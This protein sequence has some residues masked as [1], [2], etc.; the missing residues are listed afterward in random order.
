MQEQIFLSYSHLDAQWTTQLQ[1]ALQS[2]G[3]TVWQDR[4]RL[5][6]GESWNA[7]LMKGLG[8]AMCMVAVL[9]PRFG[10]SNFVQME[11]AEATTKNKPV[12]PVLQSRCELPE[13]LSYLSTLQYVDFANEPFETALN[14]LCF[15]LAAW[16]VSPAADPAA[17]IDLDLNRLLPGTWNINLRN[18]FGPIRIEALFRADCTLE[19]V[20]SF[21]VASTV[22]IPAFGTWRLAGKE[23]RLDVTQENLKAGLYYRQPRESWAIMFHITRSVFN[24]LVGFTVPASDDP[25]GRR[26]ECTWTRHG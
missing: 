4:E 1:S 7:L 2:C 23:I 24:Q 16:G 5:R 21:P 17:P 22:V 3:Y 15:A 25:T 11:V 18:G 8:E 20:V 26:Y 6:G 12:I 10:S 14:R 9:S 13:D 19:G